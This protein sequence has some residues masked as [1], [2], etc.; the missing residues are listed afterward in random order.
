MLLYVV[1]DRLS[2]LLARAGEPHHL[3]APLPLPLVLSDLVPWH[4]QVGVKVVVVVFQI[5]TSRIKTWLSFF[6]KS[7]SVLKRE[8][9]RFK[10]AILYYKVSFKGIWFSDRQTY[11]DKHYPYIGLLNTFD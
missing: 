2:V 5:N 3:L 1:S 7:W 11:T 9:W 4:T 8:E 6:F 10:N